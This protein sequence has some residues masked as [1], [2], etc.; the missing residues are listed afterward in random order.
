MKMTLI[1]ASLCAFMVACASMNGGDQPAEQASS[2]GEQPALTPQTPPNPDV[3][4]APTETSSAPELSQENPEGAQA[5]AQVVNEQRTTNEMETAAP[6]TSA[7]ETFAASAQSQQ[8]P[9]APDL[10]PA[11]QHNE[12]R[13]SNYS[14]YEEPRA[15]KSSKLSAAAKAKKAKALALAKKKSEKIAKNG[16]HGKKVAKSK[17]ASKMELAKHG[18]KKSKVAKKLTK[19]E[20]KKIAKNPKKSLKKEIAMCKAEK[21]K[22]ASK[23]KK[24]GKVAQANRQS[25]LQ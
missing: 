14:S 13:V 10:F 20:C 19:A 9:P 11:A 8:Q 25:D 22:L 12:Q 4:M 16:K 15:K 3:A 24:L 6:S 5:Q 21:K 17:K 18:G 23:S 2:S 7:G 1:L